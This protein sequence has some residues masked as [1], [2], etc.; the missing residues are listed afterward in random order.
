MTGFD[1]DT[2]VT[3]AHVVTMDPRRPHAT[4][5]AV[6]DGRFLAVGDDA[7]VR[8]LRG[9]RTNVRDLGGAA[10]TPGLIDAH[11]HPIQ[12]IELTA[13]ID[14]G[15]L[16]SGAA[17]LAAL[18]AEADRALAEDADPWVRG[19]NVD[20]DVFHDLPMTATAIEDA[21]RG[22]PALLILFDGHTALASRA[23][24]ER[25]GITGG[26]DFDDSSCIVVDAEGHPTGELRELGAYEPVRLSAPALDRDRTLAV[27]SEILRGLRSSGITG[28]TIM[29]GGF[30][31]LALLDALEQGP[32]LP[33]R[34]VSAIDHEPG[35]DEERTAL[36]LGMRDRRGDRWRG[37]VVKLY[38]DGVVE[39]GTAWLYEP[40]T[41]GTGLEPF[42]KDA[43]AYART[44]RRY[45]DAG[46]QVATHAI[47]DRAVGEV[48]DAYLAAGV[49]SAGGAPHRIEHLETT[50]DRDVA[51][52][53]A[54]GI[55]VS[56]Q[57]LHMQWRKADGSDDWSRRLGPERAGRAWRARDYWDAGAPVALGS[58][59]PIAQNDAR[60]G[61]AWTM[62]RRRPGDR[63]A[64][65]FEPDQ[66]LT[67]YQ[68]LHGYTVGAARAQGDADLGRIAPGFRADYA[69]WAENPL[70]VAPDDLPDLPVQATVVGGTE[71]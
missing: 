42:W 9:P 41:A 13:G 16:T 5:F 52:I 24:L 33:I 64:P 43:A 45:A 12:G 22:L 66:V 25:A 29:D 21:V 38:A 46:F 40:D 36:N 32:G 27:G 26:R 3:G 59:W 20:Y 47:G 50:T 56:M 35:F 44:V 28:G 6:R 19:W 49:R 58:D 2:I 14:L 57:P 17:L 15:G 1:A 61:L 37:G 54:A 69:V 18:R 23:G 55:T 67:P 60:I 71:S 4:A 65:V 63:D 34:I 62:L 31:T 39:T 68:A 48:V 8:E 30:A 7:L 10:V 51:R 11:L 53:A 70:H